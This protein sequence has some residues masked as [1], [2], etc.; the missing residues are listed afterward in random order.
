MPNF[1]FKNKNNI[2]LLL[3]SL[4]LF[5]G[6]VFAG[7]HAG[8][9]WDLWDGPKT[10]GAQTIDY[11]NS[12]LEKFSKILTREI[13]SSNLSENDKKIVIIMCILSNYTPECIVRCEVNCG[14]E[15]LSND[16]NINNEEF[17]MKFEQAIHVA[18]I[19]PYR[20]TTHNKGIFNGIDA[21]VI[22]TGND[23]RA[24]EACGHTYA[25]KSGQ[26]RSLSNVEIKDGRFRF[27]IDLP[28]SVGTVGGLTTLHPM[29]RF[30]Y[31]LLG[32]PNSKNL[33]EIIAAVGLAQN[34]GAIRSLVT[35]GI[36][37]GHMKMHLLNILN[38][39]GA[40]KNEVEK[41]KE[42]FKDK[43]VEHSAV[44]NYFKELRNISN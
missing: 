17:A 2:F 22:A 33:M 44:V 31:K 41:T 27:W 35:T 6:A 13:S 34:F 39:L 21:V 30:S 36:Q 16:P 26:Y 24:V 12:L 37:K 11:S 25:S 9:E 29:V 18:N 7:W 14:I 10:C 4:L 42:Y 43:V 15:E 38:Q 19:E 8:I 5:L 20:A 28:I 40:D 1:I 3:I 23:F 32:N